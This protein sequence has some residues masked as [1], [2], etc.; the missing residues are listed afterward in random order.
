M[1]AP[2]TFVVPV[3]CP[4]AGCWDTI[5]CTQTVTFAADGLRGVIASTGAVETIL[6]EV[7]SHLMA[8]HPEAC[9]P[10]PVEP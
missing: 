5:E 4:V 8:E 10:A 9:E 2:H 6:A 3:L 1:L 7:A